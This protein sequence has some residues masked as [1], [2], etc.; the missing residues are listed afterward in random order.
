[1]KTV[2]LIRVLSV[3]I[4]MNEL[5]TGIILALQTVRMVNMATGQHRVWDPPPLYLFKYK[6]DIYQE[7]TRF[8]KIILNF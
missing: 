5:E 3:Q 6:I 1:M 2:V 7:M 4:Q 8:L